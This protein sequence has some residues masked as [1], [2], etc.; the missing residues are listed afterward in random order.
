MPQRLDNSAPQFRASGAA[1]GAA[2]ARVAIT[3]GLTLS[4]AVA[5]AGSAA[6]AQQ[7]TTPAIADSPTAQTLFGDISAQAKE[8]PAESARI[9]RRL[10]DEYGTRVVRIGGDTDDLFTSVGAETERFL[11]ENPTI[12]ARFRDMES[13][14]A[15][16]MLAEEG[17][18]ETSARRRLTPAGLTATL[19]LA[20]RAIRADQAGAARALLAKVARH[21]DLA[22]ASLVAWA[23]LEAM[24]CRR[25]GDPA[26]ADAA[27]ARLDAVDAEAVDAATVARARAAA[28]RTAPSKGGVLGRSPLV[29]AP[30]GGD[31]DNTWREIWARELDQSL[32]KRLNTGIA[33]TRTRDLDR[34]R[35]EARQ[36]AALPTVLGNRIYISEG[37]RVR[38]VDVDSSD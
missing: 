36:M 25:S 20:E 32:F 13:R 29:S 17:P 4:L 15:E 5:L 21:P 35:S 14:A 8:N 12:L 22:G 16:R 3:L 24:A 10:L 37:H 34:V 9:A 19:M 26:G 33:A 18:L 38:A 28:V 30:D 27:L 23:S 7:T 6:M 31:P 11:L 2:T 1:R